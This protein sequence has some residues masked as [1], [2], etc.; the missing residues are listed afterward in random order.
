MYIFR[1]SSSNSVLEVGNQ[2][3]SRVS[4]TPCHNID[5]SLQKVRLIYFFIIVTRITMDLS[6]S[7]SEDNDIKYRVSNNFVFQ[8][9]MRP[10]ILYNPRYMTVAKRI[11]LRPLVQAVEAIQKLISMYNKTCASL[12][13][14]SNGKKRKNAKDPRETHHHD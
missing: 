1:Y 5:M 3:S 6:E 12:N 11:S 9:I 4:Q 13:E 8:S 14:E 2:E 10:N 7:S